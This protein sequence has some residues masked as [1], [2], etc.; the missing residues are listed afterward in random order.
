MT[1]QSSITD[2]MAELPEAEDCSVS[3]SFKTTSYVSAEHAFHESPEAEDSSA[4]GSINK[5]TGVNNAVQQAI[6]QSV[7]PKLSVCH[8][9]M[10]DISPAHLWEEVTV[11]DNTAQLM[12]CASQSA[13]FLTR[14]PEAEDCV[15]TG[16]SKAITVRKEAAQQVN[17]HL[18]Y[19]D[20]VVEHAEAEERI[21]V[22]SCE[23]VVEFTG[24]TRD[25][26][27][28]SEKG[29]TVFTN[30]ELAFNG[31]SSCLENMT[32][33]LECIPA[34]DGEPDL[35]DFPCL[36][37]STS[38]GLRVEQ[39]NEE[40]STSDTSDLC[41][42]WSD[43]EP[44]SAEASDCQSPLSF[45]LLKPTETNWATDVIQQRLI[46]NHRTIQHQEE[47]ECKKTPALVISAEK[48]KHDTL[49]N[50]HDG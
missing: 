18:Q 34:S 4:V 35:V 22:E 41:A 1:E 2:S 7:R 27:D 49:L 31:T 50:A 23:T 12:M 5:A 44:S 38:E 25:F 21:A 46:G 42:M 39:F 14:F 33:E 20:L 6:D 26:L 37:R 17:G 19:R 10:Y 43:V 32:C 48:Q 29:R 36:A 3:G 45:A 16:S 24:D 11:S 9:E 40:T 8:T 15:A 47:L 30:L 13:D 28:N